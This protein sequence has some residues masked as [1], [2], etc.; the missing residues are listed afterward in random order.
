MKDSK[1]KYSKEDENKNNPGSSQVK[2][3]NQSQY[4]SNISQNDPKNKPSDSFL[5]NNDKPKDSQVKP[6]SNNQPSDSQFKPSDS[7]FKPNDSQ[8]K[9]ND[10]QVKPNNS[11]KPNNSNKPYNSP[12]NQSQYKSAS[13]D[14]NSRFLQ[15]RSL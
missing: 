2:P 12:N 11:Y 8:F 14:W 10:S 4:K 3:G 7:Q 6:N 13:K 15:E 1:I 5:F 9:P